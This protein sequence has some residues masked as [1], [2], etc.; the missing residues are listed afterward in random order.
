MASAIGYALVQP[1]GC[2]GHFLCAGARLCRALYPAVA[3]P[4]AGTIFTASGVWMDI[5]KR[6]LAFP[7]L[8]A[9]TAG[10][11]SGPAGG[12]QRAGCCAGR[13]GGAGVCRLAVWHG[14]APLC[15]KRAQSAVQRHGDIADCGDRAAAGA[16][17]AGAALQGDMQTQVSKQTWTPQAWPP[18]R[19]WQSDFCRFYRIMVHHLSG[20]RE[21]LAVDRAVKT[22]LAKPVRCTWWQTRLNLTRTLMT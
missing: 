18:A 12:Q 21:D 8:G 19:A 1:C 13:L 11:D 3:V 20:E 15:R 16:D 2:A 7:M 14:A 10:V 4:A 9:G 5:L 17:Q 6:G 22:A